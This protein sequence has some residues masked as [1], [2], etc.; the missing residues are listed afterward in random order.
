MSRPDFRDNSPEEI[1]AALAAAFSEIEVASTRGGMMIAQKM[2]EVEQVIIVGM[3]EQLLRS[4][5]WETGSA[6]RGVQYATRLQRFLV[7][8]V[9]TSFSFHAGYDTGCAE[10]VE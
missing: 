4:I 9:I 3:T 6:V 10:N 1:E 5:D 7:E 2:R 8:V